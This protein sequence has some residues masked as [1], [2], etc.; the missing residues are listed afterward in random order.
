MERI[1]KALRIAI[2]YYMLF[3]VQRITYTIVR[4]IKFSRK[5]KLHFSGNIYLV[6]EILDWNYYFTEHINIEFMMYPINLCSCIWLNQKK[7]KEF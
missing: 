4:I 5:N 3:T 7:E 1:F 2:I 6:L